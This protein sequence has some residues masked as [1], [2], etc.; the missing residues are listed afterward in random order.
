MND[1]G[2]TISKLDE[3]VQ[4]A[5]KAYRFAI[6]SLCLSCFALGWALARHFG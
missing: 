3:A 1:L 6:F 5:E 2:N 4:R